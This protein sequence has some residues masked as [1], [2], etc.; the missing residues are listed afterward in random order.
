MS[1]CNH[2]NN[3]CDNDIDINLA[4]NKRTY[5]D[6]FDSTSIKQYFTLLA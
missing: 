1:R 5:A 6:L 4:F 3:L 2:C